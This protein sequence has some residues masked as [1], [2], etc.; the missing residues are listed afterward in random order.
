MA[1]EGEITRVIKKVRQVLSQGK[2]DEAL[3]DLFHLS[4]K[5][6]DAG[7][8]RPEIAEVLIGRGRSRAK[9][10]KI[11][12]ACDDF[13]RSL[14]WV[15]TPAAYVELGRALVE[16]GQLD[17]AHELYTKA[18]EL[19]DRYGP[20]YEALGYLLLRWNEAG[21]SAKAFEQ[22]LGAGH[23]TPE[24]YRGVW[25]A[26]MTLENL[27]RAH[28]LILEG[29]ERFPGNDM[30]QLAAG[31]SCVYAKG[32]SAAAE[33]YWRKSVELNAK[34]FSA[35][36]QLAGLEAS[37]GGRREALEL[38]GKCAEIDLDETRRRWREDLESPMGRFYY[39]ARDPEFRRV[40]G[41]QN[42]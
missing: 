19:D 36:F 6:P 7:E 21:E 4:E 32:D 27:D 10:G 3:R 1:K 25:N 40:L 38:L 9:R 8:I 11:K 30:V 28:E 17:Y 20:A 13:E 35:L 34:N 33:P 24:L 5:Y 12:E 29:T 31:D 41:W 22:A 37:R 39:V 16:K 14:N 15:V 18:L 26:Y 23:A 2:Y 42:D